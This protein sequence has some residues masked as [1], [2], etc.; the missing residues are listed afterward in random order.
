MYIEG[1][2]DF[3]IQ[4]NRVEGISENDY[5]QAGFVVNS[6]K[7]ISRMTFKS[8]YIVD[9]YK[10][11]FLYVSDNPLF[12]CG[13]QPDEVKEM[14][15]TFYTNQVPPEELTMLLEIN[16]AG[17]E[18]YSK[19]PIEERMNLCISYDFHVS[20]RGNVKLFNHKLTPVVLAGNGN[21]WL[22]ACIVSL[23]SNTKAGN[24]EAHIHGK[25]YYWLYSLDKHQWEQNEKMRLNSRE[26]EILLLSTQGLSEHAISGKIHISVPTVKFHKRNLFEKLKVRNL[27]AA[28]IEASNKKLL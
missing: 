16:R 26:K 6:L 27:P 17:F 7:A 13:F 21:I 19:T 22:A 28:I 11:N 9:Y 20:D 12:L 15:Y 18:F 25:P 10:K 8:I 2:D 5:K 3:F 23:S 4:E 24:V 1:I 14:G